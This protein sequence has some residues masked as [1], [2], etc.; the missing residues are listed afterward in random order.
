[1]WC[2]L[3]LNPIEKASEDLLGL[4]YVLRSA[5]LFRYAAFLGGAEPGPSNAVSLGNSTRWMIL[6]QATSA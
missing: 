4:N 2:D 1:M 6:G 3:D 5:A